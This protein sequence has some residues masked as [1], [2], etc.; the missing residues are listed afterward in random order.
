MVDQ[1]EAVDMEV[2]VGEV[3]VVVV[4]VVLAAV[5]V[6]VEVTGLFYHGNELWFQVVCVSIRLSIALLLGSQMLVILLLLVLKYSNLGCL[7]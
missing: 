5:T 7:S 3:R 6:V 2:L 4:V 1:V